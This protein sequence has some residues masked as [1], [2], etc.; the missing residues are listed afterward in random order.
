MFPEAFNAVALATT[1]NLKLDTSQGF[2]TS[3]AV[4]SNVG[5]GVTTVVTVIGPNVH[6]LASAT[7]IS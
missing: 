6:P 4:I 1:S 7:Q 3:V 5:L 2:K